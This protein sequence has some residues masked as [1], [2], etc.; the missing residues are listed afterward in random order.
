MNMVINNGGSMSSQ[1]N[2]LDEQKPA[3]KM[4]VVLSWPTIIELLLQ[5]TVNYVDTAMVG[6]IGVNATASIG[7][8]MSTLW[9]F[10]G[11][12]NAVAVGFSVLMA[13]RIGEG[14]LE[15]ARAVIRQAIL[16]IFVVGSILTTIVGGFVAPRLPIWMKTEPDVAPLATSYL[17]IVGA[18]YIFNVSLIVCSN[19]LRCAGDTRTPMKF[20]IMTN[21]LNVF[22]N[23]LLI[24]P[25]KETSL[26][27]WNFTL[28]RAGLGVSGAALATS[29]SVAFSGT[30]LLLTLFLKQSSI[31]I[32]LKESFAPRK[33]IISR[34]IKL[35]IPVAMERMTISLG[36]VSAAALI[37]SLGTMSLAANQLADTGESICYL[38]ANGFST[39]GTTL[40]A[41][42]L[43][44]G[45]KDLAFRYG[46]WCIRLAVGVMLISSLIMFN[47]A[48]PIIDIFSDDQ[49][50][51][52]LA[53]R[54]LR[55]EAFAEPLLAVGVVIAGIL[56]GAGDTKWPFYI[57]V[58][59]MWLIRIPLAYTLV[60]VFGWGLESIWVAMIADWCVRASMSLCRFYHKKWMMA[61]AARM[62]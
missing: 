37:S 62:K 47:L 49:P 12:M 27:G 3:W 26:F 58:A 24:Y 18:A 21:I 61:S 25:S 32:S 57:S 42:S 10:N 19:I 5:T 2:V 33:D 43:G 50:T 35:G 14:N 55:I 54:M 39:A 48:V 8:T 23:Y 34:A 52:M 9:L 38:P 51:V 56:R 4:A 15:E 11:V 46:Q 28:R 20:N 44:A 31:K 40:V 1:V 60:H 6:S 59:G 17:R 29:I 53:A 30:S 16:S 7:V 45:K 41:Q 22:G 13:R 36:Q